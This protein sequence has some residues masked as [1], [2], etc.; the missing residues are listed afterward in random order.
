MCVRAVR[1]D[2][3][4]AAAGGR[5]LWTV[6]RQL[7]QEHANMSRVAKIVLAGVP[8]QVSARVELVPDEDVTVARE[9]QPT[10]SPSLHHLHPIITPGAWLLGDH[11]SP[12]VVEPH[13]RR[14]RRS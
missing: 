5:A 7:V 13:T 4:S 3:S 12:G 9:H 2:H 6:V 11:L 14:I 1:P 8:D 10:V